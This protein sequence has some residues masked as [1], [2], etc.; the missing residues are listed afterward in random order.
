[1]IRLSKEHIKKLANP[2]MFDLDD[3]EIEDILSEFTMLTQQMNDLKKIDTS[4]VVPMVYPY[5]LETS[6]LREDDEI[7][8]L[9]VQDVLMNAPQTEDDYFVVPKVIE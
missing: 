8:H 6:Y 3:K 5:D 4:D 9:S 7:H 2:L 1:M